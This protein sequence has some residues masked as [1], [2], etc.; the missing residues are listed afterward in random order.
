MHLSKSGSRLG[1]NF[2]WLPR[3]PCAEH[4]ESAG[5]KP[6]QTGDGRGWNR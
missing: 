6:S 3:K 2:F 4:R 1:N 5:N